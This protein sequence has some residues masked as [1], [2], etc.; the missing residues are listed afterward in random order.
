MGLVRFDPSSRGLVESGVSLGAPR[1]EMF[2]NAVAASLDRTLG[3]EAPSLE[4]ELPTVGFRG[5]RLQDFV[6][7]IT[8]APAFT[9]RKPPAVD[10]RR[11][12]MTP[13]PF[14]ADMVAALSSTVS[15][16]G[17]SRRRREAGQ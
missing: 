13:M 10:E 8:T 15:S 5:S 17:W 2:L 9:I 6:P 1:V 11:C 3:T 4:A 12:P 16:R 14:R 7:P